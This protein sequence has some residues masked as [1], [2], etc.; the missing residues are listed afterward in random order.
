ML[1]VAFSAAVLAL[2]VAAASTVPGRPAAPTPPAA[3]AP[4]R[5][6]PNWRDELLQELC[7]FIIQFYQELDC[8]SLG[9]PPSYPPPN[10]MP[11][12]EC[13]ALLADIEDFFD[14]F[15]QPPQTPS[16]WESH[17]DA[18]DALLAAPDPESDGETWS[19]T[20][21]SDL[22]AVLAELEAWAASARSAAEG[23]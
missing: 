20:N 3:A 16:G 17:M 18:V 12:A 14:D 13:V 6:D 7:W 1:R 19:E 10:G 4:A 22:A 5:L 2:A 8:T 11:P 9:L 21:L 15:T 23:E